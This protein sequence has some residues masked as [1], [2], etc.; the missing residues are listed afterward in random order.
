MARRPRRLPDRVGAVAAPASRR[1]HGRG[2]Q[3]SNGPLPARSM[4]IP[5][6]PWPGGPPVACAYPPVTPQAL[7]ACTS[8]RQCPAVTYAETDLDV[9]CSLTP[10]GARKS[11][12]PDSAICAA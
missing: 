4:A 12:A 7:R 8:K 1:D 2:L 6:R 5:A 9:L 10:D 3:L 11:T